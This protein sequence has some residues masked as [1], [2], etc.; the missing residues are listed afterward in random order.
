M[1]IRDSAGTGQTTIWIGA[2]LNS[3]ATGHSSAPVQDDANYAS[4]FSTW[5]SYNDRFTV[6][7][8]SYIL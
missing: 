2:N 7:R 1:C 5:D 8:I 3:F 4:W 6:N